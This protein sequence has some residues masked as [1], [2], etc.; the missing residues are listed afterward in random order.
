MLSKELN[1][2]LLLPYLP[3]L[4]TGRRKKRCDEKQMLV[5]WQTTNYYNGL[6]NK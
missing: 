2:E 5:T 6:S 3:C 4:P 1:N